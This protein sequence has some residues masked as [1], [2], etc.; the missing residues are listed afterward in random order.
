M[1][2]LQ[3]NCVYAYGSTGKIVEDITKYCISKGDDVIALYGRQGPDN[4]ANIIKVS[5]EFEAKLHSIMSRL[6]GVDFAYSPLSTRKTIR[7]IKAFNPDIVHLHCLNGHFINVYS[8]IDFL[9]HNHITTI[10][11][12]HS[13]IMH[14]AGCEHAYECMKWTDCCHNCNRI[15]G[16]LTHY[17]RDDA[18]YAYLAMQDAFDGFSNL[19][20]ASVSDWLTNRA[21][22]SAVFQHS[23][24]KFITINNGLNLQFFHPI[25]IDD[26]PLKNRF[27]TTRP[28]ILH[29]TPNFLHPL[30]G[31]QYVINLANKHIDWHFVIVG[32]NGDEKLPPNVTAV[33]RL[34]NNE[35]LSWYYN[36]ASITLLTSRR[37]TFSMVCA[38]SL[39]CGTPIVGFEAGGPESIF[40]GNYAKFVEYGNDDALDEAVKT[41]LLE[42]PEVD[43]SYIHDRFSAERMAENYRNCYCKLI[44]N[45]TAN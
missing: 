40:I 26:N 37:E 30:K 34:Q 1:K 4:T 44:K 33:S 28:I 31:G 41:M 23:S 22:K 2:I 16:Y 14:T 25:I 19:T 21:K 15:K 11:T 17:F 42:K 24:A 32:F 45:E 9:K 12:L 35:E 18:K 5:S 38:E 3:I 36:I 10:L 29:V 8:L 7:I 39:A 27:D 43:I 20:I 6:T 13:E